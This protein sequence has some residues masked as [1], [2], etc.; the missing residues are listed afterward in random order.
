MFFSLEVMTLTTKGWLFSWRVIT[1]QAGG[2]AAHTI[3]GLWTQARERLP[4]TT[5]ILNNQSYAILLGDY[6][7]VGAKPSKMASGMMSL[8]RPEIDGCFI[9]KGFEVEAQAVTTLRNF[10]TR[11]QRRCPLTAPC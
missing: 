6:A 8:D 4:V 10:A 7:K 11:W 9:A 3:Q 2:P 5:L 1:L